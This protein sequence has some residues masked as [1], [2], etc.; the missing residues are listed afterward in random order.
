MQYRL[1]FIAIL[2]LLFSCNKKEID[3][4]AHLKKARNFYENADYNSAQKILDSLKTLYPNH[5]KVRKEVLRLGRLVKLEQ[6]TQNI[7]IFDSL[8]QIR[9]AQRDS[10]KTAFVFEKKTEYDNIGKYY[11]KSQILENNL[12]RSY[13]RSGVNELG[14]MELASIYCGAQPIRHTGLKVSGAEGEYTET[15]AIPHDGGMNYSFTDLNMTIETVT[16]TGKKDNGVIQFI[17]NNMDVPIKA[18]YTGGNGKYAIAVSQADKAA[19]AN[20]RD[21]SI[22]LSDISR[23]NKE[24]EKSSLRI[25]YF[26]QKI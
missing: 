12:R 25:A 9:L 19:L 5:L 4:R 17:Y 3:A 14:V 10:M 7:A 23:L 11:A 24:I 20:I 21:F 1:F 15:E 13:I 22:I 2:L 18:E 6:Q 16:Y 8:L 26:R